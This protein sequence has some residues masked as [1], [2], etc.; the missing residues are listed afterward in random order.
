[1]DIYAISLAANQRSGKICQKKKN[2]KNC[3]SKKQ[4]QSSK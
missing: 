4:K 2:C 1:M 3:M